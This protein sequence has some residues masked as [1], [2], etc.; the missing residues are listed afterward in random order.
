MELLWVVLALLV[1]ITSVAGILSAK[2]ASFSRSV[3]YVLLFLFF[4]LAAFTLFRIFPLSAFV[5]LLPS[6]LVAFILIKG[7]SFQDPDRHGSTLREHKTE[8]TDES[9]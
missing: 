8:K 6:L 1:V 5:A 2:G 7:R 4:A 9:R 3:F